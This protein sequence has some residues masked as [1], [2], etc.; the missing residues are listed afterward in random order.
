[1]KKI[2]SMHP[3]AEDRK[4]KRN[5][6]F[7]S[8][9]SRKDKRRRVSSPHRETKPKCIGETDSCVP[10]KISKCTWREGRRIVELGVLADQLKEGCLECKTVLNLFNTEEE[11][12]RGLG[13]ILYVR[14]EECHRLNGI[15]TGKTHRSP[16][17][18]DVGRPIWDINTKAATGLCYLFM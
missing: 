5:G 8:S 6:R 9:N 14:C 10:S 1:M 15:K 4:R 3:S 11:T 13:S 7:A 16:H 12:I 2:N 17:E 18:K